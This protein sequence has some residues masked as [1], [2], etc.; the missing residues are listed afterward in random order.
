MNPF[1]IYVVSFLMTGAYLLTNVPETFFMSGV[2]LIIG[3]ILD[4]Q[5]IIIIANKEG[6]V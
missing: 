1:M 5:P 3:F 6:E 4:T 2:F